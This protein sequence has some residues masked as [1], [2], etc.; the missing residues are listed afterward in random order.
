MGSKIKAILCPNCNKLINGTAEQCIHCGLKNPGQKKMQF[1]LKGILQGDIGIIKIISY[2][3]VGLFVLSHLLDP[4]YLFKASGIF[5]FLS[6]NPEILY[7]LGM[8]GKYAMSEGHWWSL[9]TAVYLHGS[10]LHILF[11]VL[12]IRQIGPIMEDL[13][14]TPRFV[15]IFTI[16]GIA[17]FIFSNLFGV[18]FTVGASG[19]IFGLLGALIF[20]GRHR[21]GVFGEAIFKQV[22]TWAVLLFIF[23]FLFS[24][25]NNYAHAGG[26]IGGYL[27]AQ[28][29]GYRE[30][31][32]E[33]SAMKTASS[34]AIIATII[35]FILA[36]WTG[37]A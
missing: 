26:F 18:R 36:F 3:C 29:L 23:G 16:A 25:I 24:G 9:I 10:L 1:A 37:I 12:W 21:G 20:Y 28:F 5:E 11:N 33:T 15:L 4:S 19:S 35:C 2:F 13:F 17:G 27:S 34:V 8:T 30:L 22:M 14:G 6:P 7:R 31:K 32:S